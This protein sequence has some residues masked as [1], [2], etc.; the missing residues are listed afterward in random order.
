[1]LAK[2]NQKKNLQY[3]VRKEGEY[4]VAQ[5]LDIEVSSFGQTSKEA[6]E[7]VQE[8]VWLYFE[9]QRINKSKNSKHKFPHVQ[10]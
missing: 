3:L 1:M 8:A 9:D 5:C 2:K 6:M 4:Y 7:N 10:R